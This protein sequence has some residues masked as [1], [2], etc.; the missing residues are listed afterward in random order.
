MGYF[1]HKYI[2]RGKVNGNL[3]KWGILQKH[4]PTGENS[5]G[6]CESDI[7]N[8]KVHPQGK[9]EWEPGTMVYFTKNSPQGTNDMF[10]GKV[11]THGNGTCISG[12]PSC[13]ME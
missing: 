4:P 7:C 9:S 10:Y 11:H 2:H 13:F 12:K 5:M 3:G 1:T 8:G 6:N